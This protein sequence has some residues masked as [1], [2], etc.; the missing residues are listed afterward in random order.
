VGEDSTTLESIKR[1]GGVVPDATWDQNWRNIQTG[2]P[3]SVVT[4]Q[5][6]LNAVQICEAAEK[7]VRRSQRVAFEP[8]SFLRYGCPP[9]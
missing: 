8:L 1:T 3:P 4:A 2:P 6:G 5:D 9:V 7:P